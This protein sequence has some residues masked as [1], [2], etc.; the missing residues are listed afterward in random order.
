MKAQID[1]LV[2]MMQ[3]LGPRPRSTSPAG[4]RSPGPCFKCGKQGHFQRECPLYQGEK[5]V[6]FVEAEPL[7]TSGSEEEATPWPEQD[8]AEQE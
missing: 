2:G 5:K 1:Q 3:K 4:D 8:L 7:N 6:S